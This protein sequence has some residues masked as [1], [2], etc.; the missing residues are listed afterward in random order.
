L[1][2]GVGLSILLRTVNFTIDYSLTTV[3]SWVGWVLGLVLGF[4]LY[5]MDLE[6]SSKKPENSKG[7]TSA[8]IG[9]MLV[10]TLIFFTFSAPGVLAR[11]IQGNYPM[12]VIMVSLMG[13][14]WFVLGLASPGWFSSLSPNL[15]AVWNALFA[16]SLVGTTLAH[17]VPFPPD[18]G[19]PPVIVGDPSWWQ[20]VPLV[21]TILLLPVIFLDFQLFAGTV[22]ERGT[23]PRALVPGLLYGSLVMVLLVFMNIFT[24]VWG[25]VEPVSPFFRNK[26]WLPFALIG[27]LLTWLSTLHRRQIPAQEETPRDPMP[28]GWLVLGVCV[29]LVTAVFSLITD[30]VS[31]VDSDPSSLVLMTYNI[32]QANDS[33]AEKSYERQLK[34]IRGVSPDI[35]ALQECDSVRIS[36]NNNDYVRYFASKLG[37]YSYFGPTPVAGTYGTAILSKYPLEKPYTLFSFSDQDE[38]GTA[39]AEINVGGQ[40]F[41]IFNVHPAGSD[42]AMEAFAG[43]LLGASSGKDNVIALGDYNLREGETAYQMIDETFT[44]AWISVYATGIGAD[45]LD[46]S[47][48]KRIDH[49]F[50]STH[51]E[52]RDPVYL[53][54]PESATDHP[55]HWAEVTWSD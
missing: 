15:V 36:L 20:Q 27:F 24:N 30:H 16:I 25:Y 52:I 49:I 1:A 7:V 5:R 50:L 33:F 14:I 42:T 37:Y 45:G 9:I 55:V 23:G 18:P 26:F 2:L 17:R 19:S 43:A 4:A 28:K 6:L 29:F 39:V 13:L 31:A 38:I 44:N 32:Q 11:W 8:T 54:A 3:G 10:L 53:L 22:R 48:D 35:L 46:M 21:F 40:R 47:G 41:T 34:L 12:I 51:L